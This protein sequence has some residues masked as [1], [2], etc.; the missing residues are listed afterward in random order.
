MNLEE[1]VPELIENEGYA[2]VIIQLSKCSVCNRP[3][4]KMEKKDTQRMRNLFPYYWKTN[5]DSQLKRA[6]IQYEGTSKDTRDNY[7][8]EECSKAGKGSFTCALCGEERSTDLKEESFGDPP[9]YLCKV[10]YESVSASV[11][12]KKTD[13]LYKSHRWDFE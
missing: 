1:F 12:S 4:I 13:E 9:E 8:C 2:K 6:G 5:L 7:V 10:C 11:W 3:M